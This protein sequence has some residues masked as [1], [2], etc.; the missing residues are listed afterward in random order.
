MKVKEIADYIESLI[1]LSQQEEYDNSGLI[2]GDPENQVSGVLVCLDVTDKVLE[3]AVQKGCNLVIAHHPL[4]FHGLKKLTPSDP[5]QQAVI[6]AI[7]NKL[8]IYAAHTNL[9]NSAAGLNALFCSKLGLKNCRI[10]S[11]TK[12]IL[13][14][15]IT[16]CP[17]N[18]ADS[19][20][21][22]LFGAGAGH[23]GNYDQCSYNLAGQGT[24]RA[25]DH[26]NPF[27]GN[28]NELHF[29]SEVRIEV[30]FPAWLQGRLIESLISV[31]P[32]EEVA[33]DIYPIL[34]E[35]KG[36]GAGMIGELENESEL[37]CFFNKIKQIT[38]IP[39]LRYHQG[40]RKSI[41]KVAVCTGSGGFLIQAAINQDADIFLTADLKYHDFFLPNQEMNL[42]D[43]GH[44]E[45][46]QMV[47]EWIYD[48]LIEKFN[49]FAIFI[50]RI[51]TNPVNY[52]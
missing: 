50:S 52:Y 29:E 49:T 6:S 16:F 46:E 28:K 5:L 2:V 32:Y 22:A 38:G 13:R 21:N 1:P 23:I 48:I 4:I 35:H 39:Y 12:D 9:D 25:L 10:L 17:D 3:E 51:N 42:V 31:H 19:L 14:K 45:S 18:H 11:P 27:V 43:M 40:N 33:Y 44:Y 20:R 7:Q 47:K 24:F 41:K 15:L 30:V 36:V 37:T 26:A 8:S 34:N